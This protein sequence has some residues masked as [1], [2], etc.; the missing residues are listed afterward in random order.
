MSRTT[1][2]SC[3]TSANIASNIIQRSKHVYLAE[4]DHTCS[5]LKWHQPLKYREI[6]VKWVTCDRVK[7]RYMGNGHTFSRE[8]FWYVKLLGWCLEFHSLQPL[9]LLYLVQKYLKSALWKGIPQILQ[10]YLSNQE[11][12]WTGLMFGSVAA[13]AS[14]HFDCHFW[15][16]IIASSHAGVVEIRDLHGG[17]DT[18]H[19]MTLSV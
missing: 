14:M 7:S 15:H 11:L 17:A 6:L 2:I 8:S 4:A 1:L 16:S 12:S 19:A 5:P 3:G 13:P 9:L 18:Q 10:I